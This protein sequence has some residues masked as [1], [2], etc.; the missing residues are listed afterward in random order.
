MISLIC[1]E[2]VLISSMASIDSCTAAPPC[3]ARPLVCLASRSAF[4]AL[5]LT[6]STLREGLDG[7]VVQFAADACPV[8]DADRTFRLFSGL[9]ETLTR[10]RI[11]A[12]VNTRLFLEFI[13]EPINDFLVD[14]FSAEV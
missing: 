12:H 3:W 4:T 13:C 7:L 14:V 6:A 8:R 9:V 11:G 5:S 2:L 1:L 10:E